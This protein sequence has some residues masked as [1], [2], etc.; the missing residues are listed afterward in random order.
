VIAG[1]AT[2]AASELSPDTMTQRMDLTLL[3]PDIHEEILVAEVEPGRDVVTERVL[4]A[5]VRQADWIEQRSRWRGQGSSALR[6][7]ST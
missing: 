3:A 2:V 6:A 1:F 4:S 7:S 5:I